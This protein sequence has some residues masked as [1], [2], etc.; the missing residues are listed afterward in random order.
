MN[1]DKEEN[2]SGYTTELQERVES[3]FWSAWMGWGI[4]YKGWNITLVVLSMI[5]TVALLLGTYIAF[6]WVYKVDIFSVWSFS[7]MY[8]ILIASEVP[9]LVMFLLLMIS[10][11]NPEIEETEDARKTRVQT[12]W[13]ALAVVYIANG[14]WILLRL[15]LGLTFVFAIP[16]AY[17][18]I[19]QYDPN[20]SPNTVYFPQALLDLGGTGQALMYTLFGFLTLGFVLFTIMPIIPYIYCGVSMG[21]AYRRYKNDPVKGSQ[22]L[23]VIGSCHKHPDVVVVVKDDDM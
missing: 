1:K 21:T 2:T 22:A 20:W 19:L 10:S 3:G 4:R 12:G 14:A 23:H 17:A 15:V 18:I 16:L 13:T 7:A 5:Y 6:S 9:P 11:E 8:I